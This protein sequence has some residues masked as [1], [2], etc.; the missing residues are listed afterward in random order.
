MKKALFI[1]ALAAV[2]ALAVVEA[3]TA[4][5]FGQAWNLFPGQFEP[6]LIQRELK[7]GKLILGFRRENQSNVILTTYP[8][9]SFSGT[10]EIWR[11]I[12]AVSNGVIVLEKTEQANYTPAR[13]ITEPEKIEWPK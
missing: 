8:S 10:V 11:D 3:L 9:P 2:A 7:D 13:T 1:A 12:Y 4:T 6:R 5:V